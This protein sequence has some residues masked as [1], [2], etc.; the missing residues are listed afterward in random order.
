M[1]DIKSENLN[2][3]D[4]IARFSKGSSPMGYAAIDYYHTKDGILEHRWSMGGE[5]L[6]IVDSIPDEIEGYNKEGIDSNE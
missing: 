2:R 3:K 6:K 1:G 5:D 4:A